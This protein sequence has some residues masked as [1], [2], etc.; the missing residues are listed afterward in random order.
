MSKSTTDD[1]YDDEIPHDD[2]ASAWTMLLATGSAL[3]LGYF[4]GR[5]SLARNVREALRRIEEA[6]EPVELSI[7]VL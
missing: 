2:L 4:A 1:K 5:V 7:R 6:P 3:V